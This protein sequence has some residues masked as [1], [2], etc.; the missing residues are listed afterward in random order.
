MST[1]T[2]VLDN[3][4]PS[5][6]CQLFITKLVRCFVDYTLDLSNGSNGIGRYLNPQKEVQLT[7]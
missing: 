3:H 6:G 2:E 7:V 1:L 4:S 5:D